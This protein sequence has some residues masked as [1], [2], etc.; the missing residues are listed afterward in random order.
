MTEDKEVTSYRLKRLGE[1]L[2]QAWGF[3]TNKQTILVLIYAFS[4]FLLAGGIW[5]AVEN[6]QWVIG[7]GQQIFFI[8]PGLSGQTLYE[9][10]GAMIFFAITL[11]GV[12][13]MY[14]STRRLHEPR[15]S[16]QLLLFGSLIFI[17]GYLAF[18]VMMQAKGLGF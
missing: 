17:F 2:D 16:S 9:T 6:A 18:T 11:A 13:L 4:L 14:Q 15:Y 3:L 1:R 12:F 10:V 7:S 5:D 8:Y